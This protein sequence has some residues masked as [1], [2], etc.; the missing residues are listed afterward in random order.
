MVAAREHDKTVF[1]A[2][3]LS[4]SRWLIAISL[5]HSEK[6]SKYR[7]SAADTVGRHEAATHRSPRL[8]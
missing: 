5:P 6:V 3:E 1:V 7:V 8:G 4:R 2:L